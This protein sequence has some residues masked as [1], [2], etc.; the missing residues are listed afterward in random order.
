M[1]ERDW[2]RWQKW[3]SHIGKLIRIRRKGK[4][5]GGNLREQVQHNGLCIV[6][7]IVLLVLFCFLLLF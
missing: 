5:K 4:K 3:S 1:R 2:G 6:L 7:L